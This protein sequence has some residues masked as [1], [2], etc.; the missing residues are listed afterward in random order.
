[1]PRVS[2]RSFL[3]LFAV[4]VLLTTAVVRGWS[5][6]EQRAASATA[7]ADQGNSEAGKKDADLIRLDPKA[8]LWIDKVRK[9]VVMVGKVCLR[10]GQL[11]MFACPE[12]TKEHESVLSVP[13]VSE[14]VHAALLAVGAR[15]GTPVEF[16]PEYKSATGSEIDVSLYWTDESGKRRSAWAQDWVQDASTGKSLKHP[17]VFAGSRFWL[18]E[19]TGKQSYL[20]NY[21]ELIC[22]SNFS[23]AM[24][25]LPIESSDKAGQLLFTAYTEHIPP[26]DTPVTIVLTPKRAKPAEKK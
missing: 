14:M 16:A 8:P 26:L 4:A 25:D 5:D 1:M 3:I 20:A 18:D 17:W 12:G 2:P 24:L 19:Q 23:S 22:V 15:Q 9:R 7:A 13:V 10:E 6:D 11:E 21:G